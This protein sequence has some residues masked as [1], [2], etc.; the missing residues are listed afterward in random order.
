VYGMSSQ[1]VRSSVRGGEEI[2]GLIRSI[3]YI[4]E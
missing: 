3:A 4:H 2:E 1:E